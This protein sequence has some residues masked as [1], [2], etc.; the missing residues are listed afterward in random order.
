MRDLVNRANIIEQTLENVG[1]RQNGSD[2]RNQEQRNQYILER[3]TILKKEGQ[4][5]PDRKLK[6]DAAKRE[7]D[8]V[9][10][11]LPKG[12]V[13]QTL[14]IIADAGERH[15]TIDI[16]FSGGDAKTERQAIQG[17]INEKQQTKNCNRQDE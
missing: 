10:Q 15:V 16:S 8:G 9:L 7:N 4:Q 17:L 1:R 11:R 14:R 2:P 6:E 12:S 3:E 13:R 5:E